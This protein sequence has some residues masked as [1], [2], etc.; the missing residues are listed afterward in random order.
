M[1][2]NADVCQLMLSLFDG[3]LPVGDGQP[4]TVIFCLIAGQSQAVVARRV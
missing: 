1:K 2:S 3:E 4:A